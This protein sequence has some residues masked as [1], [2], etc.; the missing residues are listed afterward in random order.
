M[1]S[2][3]SSVTRGTSVFGTAPFSPGFSYSSVPNVA[4]MTTIP[5]SQV[6]SHY[7]IGGQTDHGPH[8]SYAGVVV[9]SVFGVAVALIAGTWYTR[10]WVLKAMKRI[11]ASALLFG[12]EIGDRRRKS[13][14]IDKPAQYGQSDIR[15]SISPFL[16]PAPTD[17]PIENSRLRKQQT[18]MRTVDPP[19]AIDSREVAERWSTID[20][21]FLSGLAS[22][23]GRIGAI[24]SRASASS[25]NL[26]SQS[27]R[28]SS[29][30]PFSVRESIQALQNEV[31]SMR[32][33]IRQLQVSGR[34]NTRV[35][36]EDIVQALSTLQAEVEELRLG[37]GV[38]TEILPSYTP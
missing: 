20:S 1:V 34:T 4:W 18:D 29:R 24:R 16:L 37:N 27:R 5:I 19:P 33:Q 6:P 13:V 2:S 14:I 38:H 30:L 15:H 12:D 22:L 31:T 28:H 11:C 9:G 8:S 7:T 17:N 36:D 10:R 26:S 35:N 32:A 3:I 23:K 25:A 21:R